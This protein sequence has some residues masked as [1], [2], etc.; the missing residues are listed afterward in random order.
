MSDLY[1]FGEIMALFLAT[2]TDSVRTASSYVMSAAGAESNVSVACT[3]LGLKVHL[4]SRLGIDQLGDNVLS[5]I[6]TE[7]V[8]T[9]HI[10]RV[11]NYTG[12]LVRNR[13]LLEPADVTYLR[14]SSAGSSIAPEDI[15]AAALSHS[16]WLHVTGITVALSESARMTVKYALEIARSANVPVSFDLNIRR[17]LWSTDEA[18]IQLFKLVENMEL[19]TGG[20]DEYEL[21]FG[22]KDPEENLISAVSQGIRTAIMTAGPELVR[23][24]HDGHRFDYLPKAVPTIDPVGSGDAFIAGT[25]S[26]IL[27]GLPLKQAIEQGSFCGASVASILGDWA[28]LPYGESGIVSKDPMRSGSSNG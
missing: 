8:D 16:R 12:A 18:K 14:R 7:G 20:V 15:D 22:S 21:V 5:Q 10:S 17:K 3:R 23:I 1:T 25:I 6:A 26:G 2:D 28:G 19:V 11:P 27:G 9:T 4:Q 13:G 24:L